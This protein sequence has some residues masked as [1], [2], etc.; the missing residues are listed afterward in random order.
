MD[1]LREKYGYTLQEKQI[2]EA[3]EIVKEMIIASKNAGNDV[4]DIAN[5]ILR[6]AIGTSS[7]EE[8]LRTLNRQHRI[9]ITETNKGDYARLGDALCRICGHSSLCIS[10]ILQCKWECPWHGVFQ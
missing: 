3:V 4:S 9:R 2:S 6:I 1:P 8:I 5:Q 7:E 10:W